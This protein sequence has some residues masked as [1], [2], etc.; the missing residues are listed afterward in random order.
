M[1][2]A[3]IGL[4]S[5]IEPRKQYLIQAIE[6]LDAHEDLQVKQQSS[7]YETEPVDYIDQAHFLNMVVE[8]ETSLTNM[9]LLLYCQRIEKELGRKRDEE[10]IDKGP[11]PIDLDIL[12]YNNEN[13]DLGTL[14]IPHPRMHERAFVI[15][16]LKEIAPDAILPTSGKSI[17]ELYEQFS[18][19]ELASVIKYEK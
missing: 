6:M 4:G 18:K 5:N 1:N 2:R 10:S 17:V 16:P 11:R 19:R 3:Y 7:I 15:V 9:D 13:R 12:L 8:I 14:R